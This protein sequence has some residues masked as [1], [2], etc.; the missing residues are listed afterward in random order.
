MQTVYNKKQPSIL[1]TL[2]WLGL[3]TGTLDG[4]AAIIW[5]H[6]T[7]AVI[8]FQYIASGVFGSAAFKGGTTMVLWGIFFHY[9][10]AYSVT[11]V[12]FITYPGF[13]STF[14]NK[15]FVAVAFALITWVFTNLL[16]VPLSQIGFGPMHAGGIIIGFLILILTIGLPIALV[17]DRYYV[18][19]K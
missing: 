9:V 10:I 18:P 11:V 1:I 19:V 5:G 13:I 16:I 4:L 2:F 3:L 6:K 7:R 17:A 8:I 12:L 14:R 15:Y